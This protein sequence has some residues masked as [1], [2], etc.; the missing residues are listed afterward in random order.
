MLTPGPLATSCWTYVSLSTSSVNM[1]SLSI[2]I[3]ILL[4][5]SIALFNYFYFIICCSTLFTLIDRDRFSFDIMM[6]LPYVK[7]IQLLWTTCLLYFLCLIFCFCFSTGSTYVI[8]FHCQ[9][10]VQQLVSAMI[11]G[12]Q[13]SFSVLQPFI[14]LPSFSNSE[15]DER[16][17]QLKL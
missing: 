14:Y 16:E 5:C 15:C 7:L 1:L 11:S 2:Q 12:P 4:C 8:Y 10:C 13:W 3:F 6:F 17:S 9:W